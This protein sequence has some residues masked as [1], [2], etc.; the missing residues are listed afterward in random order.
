MTTF[1]FALLLA[2]LALAAPLPKFDF[3][4]EPVEGEA[5]S[6]CTKR[7]IQ[8]L[9]D[10]DVTCFTPYAKKTFS[11]HVIVREYPRAPDTGVEILYWVIEPGDKP[12]SP[13]KYHSASALF[14]LKGATTVSDFSLSQGVE[15]DQASLVL[16]YVTPQVG[17]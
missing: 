6:A 11:A 4:Y 1:F 9:P 7:Q 12:T 14:H 2:P 15:N 13:R 8:D 17:R 5:A 10:W 16:N 3:T